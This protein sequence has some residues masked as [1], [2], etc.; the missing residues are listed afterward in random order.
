LEAGLGPLPVPATS[1]YTRLDGIV[2]W[3]PA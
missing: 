2:A 3:G 1:V